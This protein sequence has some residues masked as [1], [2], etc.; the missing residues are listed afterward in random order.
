MFR[1]LLAA[2]YL[3]WPGRFSTKLCADTYVGWDG[4]T[5]REI[6]F[7]AGCTLL[8]RGNILKSLGGFDE[9]F[10]HQYEDADLCKRV[11]ESGKSVLY[12]P[13]A[14]I[15]HIGGAKRG[16]YPIKVLLETQRGKYKYFYKHHGLKDAKRMRWVS[17][18][19]Y[20]VRFA[21]YSVVRVFK[22]SNSLN[23]RLKMYRV[24]LKWHWQLNPQRFIE[25]GEEPKPGLRTP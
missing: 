17:L 21:G 24:V 12:C 4:R 25:N 1:Q 14:E 6:G 11:W 3:R 13:D 7:Q 9:R 22:R 23:D 16:N 20:G 19:D 2:L 15:I 5:E 10:L 8:I 18:I